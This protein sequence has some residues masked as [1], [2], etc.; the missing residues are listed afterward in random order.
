MEAERHFALEQMQFRIPSLWP[1]G[2][3]ARLH[4]PLF[5]RVDG[6]FSVK[7]KH[8]F[9]VGRLQDLVGDGRVAWGD[10]DFGY[11]A[12]KLGF[13]FVCVRNAIG[14]H[15]DYSVRDFSACAKRWQRTSES[16][17]KLFKVY[18]EIM[19]DIAMFK[20]KAPI[21][22]GKDPARM[23]VRKLLRQAAS[24]RPVIWTLEKSVAVLEK[25]YPSR[26][27]LRSLYRWVIGGYM[28]RGFREGLSKYGN[29]N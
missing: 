23:T 13:E 4:L 25:H 26:P 6:L 28:F 15:D 18:P 3:P 16:A 7:G 17:V 12:S 27:L 19:P 10:V 29:P 22:W 9:E 11:R 5:Q 14:Y 1:K 20:D 24:T 8:F 21:Q 2:T